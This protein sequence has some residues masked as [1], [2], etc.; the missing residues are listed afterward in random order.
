MLITSHVFVYLCER[1]K[2]IRFESR[3]A[4]YN[5]PP[6]DSVKGR[7]HR[8]IMVLQRTGY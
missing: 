5:A 7:L 4:A 2:C 3:V 8:N 1:S 6:S